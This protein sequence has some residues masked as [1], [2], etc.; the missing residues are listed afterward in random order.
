MSVLFRETRLADGGLRVDINL[1]PL[2]VRH[3]AYHE[4]GHAAAALVLARGRGVP[5]GITQI[6]V[7]GYR[8]GHIIPELGDELRY[9][10]GVEY[11]AGR[12]I[13]RADRAVVLLA[14]PLAEY[15]ARRIGKQDSMSL[16]TISDSSDHTNF[17]A[18]FDAWADGERPSVPVDLIEWYLDA[19]KSVEVA[20]YDLLNEH[21]SVVCALAHALIRRR[22]LTGDEA[23]EI[24]AEAMPTAS[25]WFSGERP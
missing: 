1:K 19:R 8:P 9:R 2:S 5:H 3:V 7:S 10:G 16:F 17:N 23:A 25:R 15:R 13:T 24:A 12:T 6:W 20:T 18:N 21:W 14:G 22:W 11:A 4:A